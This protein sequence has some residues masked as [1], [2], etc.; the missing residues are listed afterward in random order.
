MQLHAHGTTLVLTSRRGARQRSSSAHKRPLAPCRAA[1]RTGEQGAAWDPDGLL[2]PVPTEGHFARRERERAEAA[3]QQAKQG[4]GLRPIPAAYLVV[5]GLPAADASLYDRPAFE[6]QMAERFLPVDLDTPGLRIMN[7]DPPIFVLP[8]FFSEKQCDDAVAAA[9]ESG[10]LVPS[11]VEAP[12]VLRWAFV[13]TPLLP[14]GGAA[15]QLSWRKICCSVLLDAA[16][17]Q[18]HP[19]LGKM[20]R[21][22]QSKGLRLL[23]QGEGA[24]WGAP[25]RLPR[26][27]QYCYESLQM[28]R[29]QQGQHFLAHED[30]FPDDLA[31]KNGFQRHATL[32]G[33]ATRFDMLNLAVRPQ[34]GKALLFF[35]ATSDG[36]SDP[37]QAAHGAA[38]LLRSLAGARGRSA[39]GAAGEGMRGRDG[40]RDW[41]LHTAEDAVDTK[42]VTQQ[43]IAR[44]IAGGSAVPRGGAEESSGA[45]ALRRLEEQQRTAAP[46]AAEV[47]LGGARGKGR[48]KKNAPAPGGGKGFGA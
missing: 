33:G 4:G 15:A 26:P 36:V 27:S 23:G 46:V 12:W 25:G 29:Y 43:W 24:A 9:L 30:G 2:P 13:T 18:A 11:K 19:H 39:G 3:G 8:D 32:L 16:V 37:R 14:A 5:G 22:L 44:G 21:A 41:S 17:Q 47:L 28:A 1:P 48:K 40:E 6:A 7:F 38:A 45:A 31:H 34:K 35:P 42:W 10:T 20:A